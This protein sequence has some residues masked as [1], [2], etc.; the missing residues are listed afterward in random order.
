MFPD[1][2]VH[3]D[4]LAEEKEEEDVA[5]GVPGEERE[6]VVLEGTGDEGDGV[7]RPGG[8]GWGVEAVLGGGAEVDDGAERERGEGFEIFRGS[9]VCDGWLEEE[10]CED[11]AEGGTETAGAEEEAFLEDSVGV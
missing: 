8:G 7:G 10:R 3:G 9:R 2:A 4:A 1:D 6:E 5:F 11:V